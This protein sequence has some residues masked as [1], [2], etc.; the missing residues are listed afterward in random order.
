M[1]FPFQIIF[2]PGYDL[3]ISG[4]CMGILVNVIFSI[5]RN[6]FLRKSEL[7]K[8]KAEFAALL[9][10]VVRLVSK[11]SDKEAALAC[12]TAVV[13]ARPIVQRFGEAGK[14]AIRHIATAAAEFNNGNKTA[15]VKKLDLAVKVVADYEEFSLK[16]IHLSKTSR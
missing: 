4:F 12:I 1:S 5:I 13:Q 7:L 10:D 3:W 11:D 2:E 9:A 6:F 16:R 8:Q 14:E 15:A